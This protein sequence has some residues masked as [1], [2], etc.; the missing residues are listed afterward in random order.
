MPS[1]ENAESIALDV[2]KTLVAE[3]L[4]TA[5]EIEEWR[6]DYDPKTQEWYTLINFS[7]TASSLAFALPVEMLPDSE[8]R[9]VS[10]AEYAACDDLLEI[11]AE[12]EAK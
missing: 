11:L 7:Q 10:E 4:K 6:N 12:D 1:I 8:W 3:V 5:R 2:I 9:Y